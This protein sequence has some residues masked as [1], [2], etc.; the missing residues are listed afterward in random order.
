MKST[1]FSLGKVNMIIKLVKEKQSLKGWMRI[2]NNY[3][4]EKLKGLMHLVTES[5]SKAYHAISL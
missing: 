4:S 2:K 5:D 3:E 1:Q